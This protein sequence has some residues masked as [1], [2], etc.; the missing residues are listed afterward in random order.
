MPLNNLFNENNK[1]AKAK[2]LF[3]AKKINK[4]I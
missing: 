1:I 4:N 2:N 3:A